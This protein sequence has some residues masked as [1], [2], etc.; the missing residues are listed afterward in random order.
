MYSIMLGLNVH[1]MIAGR[2][3]IYLLNLNF[4]DFLKRYLFSVIVHGK[5]YLDAASNDRVIIYLTTLSRCLC[6]ST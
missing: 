5:L 3:V 1:S 4:S 6:Y 2:E